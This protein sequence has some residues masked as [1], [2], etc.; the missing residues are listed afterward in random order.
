MVQLPMPF[1]NMH[2]INIHP[3]YKPPPLTI[4]ISSQNQVIP[5]H[6]PFPHLPVLVERPVLQPVAP[7]PLPSIF[8]ILILVPELHSDTVLSERE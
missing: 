1:I 7:L 3:I 8:S 6:H 2:L 4:P 5:R